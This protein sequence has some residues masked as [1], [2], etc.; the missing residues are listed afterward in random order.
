MT[1]FSTLILVAVAGQVGGDG[2]FGSAIPVPQSSARRTLE[3]PAMP[4][5]QFGAPTPAQPNVA[6]LNSNAS[7]R[8]VL[9][10]PQVSDLNIGGGENSFSSNN[11]L[12]SQTPP[13]QFN[14]VPTSN[15]TSQES[16]QARDAQTTDSQRAEETAA[17]RLVRQAFPTPEDA[18]DETTQ[19][20]LH[21]V[22]AVTNDRA[23]R[24]VAIKTYWEAA[25]LLADWQF[26]S[27]EFEVLRQLPAARD[28]LQQS[29]LA[30][31]QTAAQARLIE[32][33]M[34][35]NSA[36]YALG[37]L[38]P[39]R[40]DDAKPLLPIDTPLTGKYNTHFETLFAAR[41][42]PPGL[43][44]IHE[45]LPLRQDLVEARADAVFA[46]ADAV[47][48]QLGA[49]Q[50][51]QASLPNV[52]RSIDNLR[53]QRGAFLGALRDYN[54]DIAEYALGTSHPN[55]TPEKVVAMMIKSPQGATQTTSTSPA[56]TVVISP[57]G[58]TSSSGVGLGL[59][60]SQLSPN[61]GPATQLPPPRA[62]AVPQ[63]AVLAPSSVSPTVAAP[64]GANSVLASPRVA[65]QSAA[66]GAEIQRPTTERV[67][68]TLRDVTDQ[69]PATVLQPTNN[70]APNG[71][72]PSAPSSGSRF[73]GTPQGEV[74]PVEANPT[75][76]SQFGGSRFGVNPDSE[77]IAPPEN[78][79]P[80]LPPLT[81]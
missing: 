23:R 27:E 31:A 34:A 16:F 76:G 42:A 54:L 81:P 29:A 71:V 58:A 48:Q 78:S 30:A 37:E 74:A 4:N 7:P 62:Q 75:G 39:A 24:T 63:G 32:A 79:E 69:S 25:T 47:E 13:P 72:P 3:A 19:L 52:L 28:P 73:G 51:G 60:P 10:T 57:A 80:T 21:D 22:I 5:S 68:G 9:T 1:T 43:R 59:P 61:Q 2:N 36:R 55:D 53:N 66:A 15:T 14:V 33:Q 11:N 40:R 46:A 38:V 6:E 50:S 8:S 26:A 17:M 70:A 49:L 67:L 35:A 20:S 77:A 56:R 41:V 64:P 18:G 45:T 12:N 44:R 65:D